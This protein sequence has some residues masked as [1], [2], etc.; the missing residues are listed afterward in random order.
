[1]LRDDVALTGNQITDPHQSTDQSGTPDVAFDFTATGRSQ[2]EKLTGAIAHRGQIASPVNPQFNQHF[3]VALDGQL[4]TVP[5]IDFKEY[6]DG[7]TGGGGAD[8]TGGFSTRAARETAAL[9]R[10][11]VLAVALTPQR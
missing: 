10:S 11:G 3:A 4:I 5:S 9:L 1:V 7:V 6:P 2:F 8:L